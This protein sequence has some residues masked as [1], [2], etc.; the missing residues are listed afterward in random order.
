[1]YVAQ[2]RDQWRGVGGV[3][4]TALNFG[5]SQRFGHCFVWLAVQC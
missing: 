1:M 5:I 2:E 3:V 4:N